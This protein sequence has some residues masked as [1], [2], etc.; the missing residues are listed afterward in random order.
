MWLLD[1]KKLGK[2]SESIVQYVG[3]RIVMSNIR[4]LSIEAF[5]FPR[6]VPKNRDILTFSQKILLNY[7]VSLC[8]QIFV[9]KTKLFLFKTFFNQTSSARFAFEIFSQT[10]HSLSQNFYIELRHCICSCRYIC[11]NI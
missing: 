2:S 7:F 11:I 5:R 6:F 8:S 1:A 9:S 4:S 10:K 3:L